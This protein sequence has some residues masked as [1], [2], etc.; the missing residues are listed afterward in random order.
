[1]IRC[2]LAAVLALTLLAVGV[3]GAE[4]KG[5][6]KYLNVKQGK[7]T[8]VVGEKDLEFMVPATAKV[9]DGGGKDLK[10]RLYALKAGDELT[11]VTEKDGDRD[12]VK[13]VRRK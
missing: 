10:G 5:K 6:L 12:A 2:Y 7:V 1:M 3:L 11:I 13:E 4:T 8:I 9:V